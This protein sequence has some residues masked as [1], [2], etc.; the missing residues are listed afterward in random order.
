MLVLGLGNLLMRDE[1]LGVCLVQRLQASYTFPD[2]VELLDGGTLGLDLL[3]YLEGASH[4]VL[5][6]AV[7]VGA[8]AGTM[9]RWQDGNIPATLGV[10]MS[11]HQIGLA[12]LLAAAS[13][14]GHMPEHMVL[15]GMQPGAVE[16]GLELT[17]EV[18][19]A[20]PELEASVLGELR[21]WGMPVLEVHQ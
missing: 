9:V 18:E 4:L 17:P 5:V 3:P 13:L 10:K 12:D 11:P 14:A 6:D 2:S 7:D 20:M 21:A 19:R 16:P 8:P 15:W 1:G